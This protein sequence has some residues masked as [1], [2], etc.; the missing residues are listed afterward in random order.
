[1]F[2][3]LYHCT[4]FIQQQGNAQYLSSQVSVVHEL[5]TSRH[6]N[7]VQKRQRNQRSN[8]QHSLDH[9]ESKGIPKT[10]TKS[11][12]CFT[13]HTKAFDYMDHKKLWKIH[14]RDGNTR[15]PYQP[16]EKFASRQRSNCQKWMWNNRLIQNW[17]RSRSRLYT[18]I[19]L[20]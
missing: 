3:L 20:I 19:L 4:H 17:E 14:T 8:S 15:P 7:W 11:H 13:D 9:R 6:T 12:F 2:K 18:V 16:L 10:K 1:M 5:R